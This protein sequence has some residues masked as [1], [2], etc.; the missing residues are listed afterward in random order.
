[1][2]NLVVITTILLS[3]CWIGCNESKNTAK[4][5]P[6]TPPFQVINPDYKTS[7]LT[8]MTRDHWKE[9]ALYL[10]EGAFNYIHSLD[11]QMVF[12]K[13]EGVSYPRHEGQLPAERLEGLCRTLFVAMPLLREDPDLTINGIK[14]AEYYQHQLKSIIDPNKKTYIQH[15]APDGGPH[16]ILVEFGA[17]A[18]SLF[19]IPDI[20]WEPLSQQEKDALAA[21]MISYGDGPTVPSNWKFFNIFVL[22]FFKEQGYLVNEVLLENYLKQTLEHYRSE[23]WYNDNPAYDYYSMWAFQMYAM[24]WNEFSGKKNYP[25]YAEQFTV[26]FREMVNNYP[27]MFNKEGQMIMWGRSITY[28]FGAISPF[29]LAG[30]LNDPSI[31]YGWLRR[32]SSSTILQF[33]EHPDLLKDGVPTLGYYGE[34]EPA[35]QGYSCRGSVYWC[36]KAFLGLLIPEE[37][38]FWTAVENNG[39]WENE[40]Q[41]GN[42]YNKFQPGSEIL[43]TDYPNS[44]ASEIRAWCHV[45]WIPAWE[46]FRA[47]ENYNKLSYNSEFPWMADGKNGEVSMNYAVKNQEEEW[48]VLR[49]Y[50]F[51]KFENGIYYRDA[52]LETNPE[53]KFRLADIPLP[54]GIL[55]VDRVQ[56][57]IPIELRLGHYS[58]PQKEETISQDVLIT[59]DK[60]TSLIANGEYSLSMEALEGWENI[61]FVTA[62]GLHPESEICVV[63]NAT[64]NLQKEK[65]Y[66][67]LQLWKKGTEPFSGEE[68]NPVQSVN[69][70]E[71]RIV[72][73]LFRNGVSKQ[74]IF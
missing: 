42:V 8:G 16:Q 72:E 26:N 30:Y 22:S 41:K 24:I 60:K 28:R 67:T 43:I 4:N 2:K 62:R 73:I 65:I 33:L 52:Y 70:R 29:P 13:Q 61:E 66:V 5:D 9:A 32:I 59:G 23:G 46:K 17:L 55:R 44:G 15:R 68:L 58:L 11:D 20:L 38:I 45:A 35:V 37:N 63:L 49:L 69:I 57:N 18:I 74:I 3:I 56:T 64:D 50:T 25:E 12:P 34:F 48:E 19:G 47:S 7:P 36:G 1:M 31:N 39:P 51:H 54:N 71:N 14:V 40:W 6:L 27:Y 10:L 21:V 53:I